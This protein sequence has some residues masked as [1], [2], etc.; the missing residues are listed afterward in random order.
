MARIYNEMTRKAAIENRL[1]G[2]HQE[3]NE[4]QHPEHR[5][6]GQVKLTSDPEAALAKKASPST[7][8][9]PNAGASVAHPPAP[10]LAPA[11]KVVPA[12]TAA[13]ADK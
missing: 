13:P 9:A 8:T 3:A 1:A 4:E 10:K 11:P 2:T 6:D 7:S 12:A 5:V